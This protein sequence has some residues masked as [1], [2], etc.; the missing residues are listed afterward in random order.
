MFNRIITAI[1]F[2]IAP[3]YY[4]R[5]GYNYADEQL[6]ESPVNCHRLEFLFCSDNPFD[7]GVQAR[8]SEFRFFNYD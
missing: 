3:K 8:L 4:Y 1:L 6:N 7:R 2:R 5:C